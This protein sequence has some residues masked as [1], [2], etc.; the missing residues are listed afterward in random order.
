MRRVAILAVIVALGA[1]VY[2]CCCNDPLVQYTA[3]VGPPHP[4]LPGVEAPPEVKRL[5]EPGTWAEFKN[6][7]FRFDEDLV[8]H[9]RSLRGKMKGNDGS[10]VAFDDPASFDMELAEAETSM[11][12]RD[13]TAL[14][15]RYVFG[16]AGAPIKNLTVRPEA[17]GLHQVGVLHKVIDI[18]FEM[19]ASVAVT[20]DGW[21]R[22]HPVEM[23]ICGLSGLGFMEALGIELEDLIDLKKAPSGIRVEHDDLLLEPLAVLPAPKVRAKLVSVRSEA[24]A[25]VQ[26]FGPSE[27]TEIPPATPAMPLPDAPNYMYFWGGVLHFGKLFMPDADM[28]V[29]DESPADPFDFFLDQ[30]NHQLVAGFTRNHTDYGLEV[31]MVDYDELSDGAR[32]A[33]PERIKPRAASG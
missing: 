21:I 13:I 20:P 16:Y 24:G 14:M 25:M 30:Y 10:P 1:A 7:D 9:V 3:S 27:G 22:I 6:V 8:L 23:K 11:G 19:R 28:Q 33:R 31:H 4:P 17:D 5:A 12:A 29:V 26:V 2:G 15:T 18:P 32:D